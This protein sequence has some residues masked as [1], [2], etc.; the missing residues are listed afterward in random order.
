MIFNFFGSLYIVLLKNILDCYGKIRYCIYFLDFK[1]RQYLCGQY[2]LLDKRYVNN[3]NEL[4][5][6][7]LKSSSIS[8]KDIGNTKI[9]ISEY[10]LQNIMHI[11]C[12]KKD[13]KYIDVISDDIF[14]FCRIKKK[15]YSIN[16]QIFPW[17]NVKNHNIEISRGNL[18][19]IE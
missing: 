17:E 7:M 3:H 10:Q 4:I 5:C 14:R 2:I 18:Y 8:C 19:R 12:L 9:P 13:N 16:V 6:P 1:R 15:I 11:C